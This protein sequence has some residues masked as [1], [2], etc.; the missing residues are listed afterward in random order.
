[1]AGI[2]QGTLFFAALALVG[3]SSPPAAPPAAITTLDVP[4]VAKPLDTKGFTDDP[5]PC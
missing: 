5:A 3:C 1:M 4:S 2:R